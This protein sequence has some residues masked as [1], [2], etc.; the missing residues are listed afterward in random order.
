MELLEQKNIKRKIDRR[1]MNKNKIEEGDIVRVLDSSGRGVECT[2]LS[3]PS[4]SG[5]MWILRERST[6]NIVFYQNPM[7]SNLDCILLLKKHE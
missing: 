5:E 4:Q 7:S 1:S 2:V 6:L 3:V